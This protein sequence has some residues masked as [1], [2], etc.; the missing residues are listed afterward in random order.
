LRRRGGRRR[1]RLRILEQPLLE[2]ATRLVIALARHRAGREIG[3]ELCNLPSQD[4]DIGRFACDAARPDVYTV[5]SGARQ[6]KVVANMLDP[7][8]ADINHSRFADRPAPEKTRPAV[9]RQPA[10]PWTVLLIFGLVILLL[11]WVAYTRRII[12]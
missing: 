1:C 11:E 5:H 6:V 3:V 7:R 9:M 12:I 2:L 10:A 8:V 4:L